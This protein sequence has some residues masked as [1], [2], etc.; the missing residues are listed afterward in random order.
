MVVLEVALK[1]P[2]TGA[3]VLAQ[4]RLLVPAT[5]SAPD[6]EPP[7]LTVNVIPEGKVVPS[8]T[9]RLL[10]VSAELME[11]L[12]ATSYTLVEVTKSAGVDPPDPEEL[13]FQ[14]LVAEIELLALV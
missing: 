14:L 9:V 8:P 2:I 13:E 11:Q 3:V 4:A 5:L 1:V 6:T 7:A 10:I 12:T